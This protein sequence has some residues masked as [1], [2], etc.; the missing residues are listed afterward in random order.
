MK[1]L[2]KSFIGFLILFFSISH[3]QKK[4]T[5]GDLAVEKFRKENPD[6]YKAHPFG[7]ADSGANTGIDYSNFN[8]KNCSEIAKKENWSVWQAPQNADE[9][10]SKYLKMRK[11]KKIALY[12]LIK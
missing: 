5:K 7:L 4:P 6:F 8:G 9:R 12:P 10:C 1:N 3:A 2:S 11:L